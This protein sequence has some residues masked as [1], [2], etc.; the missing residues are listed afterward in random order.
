MAEQKP[1]P[2]PLP[3]PVEMVKPPDAAVVLPSTTRLMLAQASGA[4]ELVVVHKRTYTWEPG[5]RAWPADVQPPL[6][7]AGV[8]YPPIAEGRAPTWKSLPEVVGYKAGTDVVIHASARS[9]RPVERLSTVLFLGKRRHEVLV[10]GKRRT[11]LH[12]GQVVFTP[13]EP[14]TEVPLR[15]E[16]AYGGRDLFY[17]THFMEEVRRVTSAAIMRRATPSMEGLFTKVSPLM[18]PRNRFGQGYVLEQRAEQ[19]AGRELPQLERPDDL[20]TPERLMLGNPLRWWQQPM[21][22][23]F[24]YLD[25]MTFPRMGMFA[26]PPPGYQ[27]G[28]GVREVELG[29]VPKDFCRGNIVIATP[30]QLPTL[31][32]PHAG[33]CASLGLNFPY[34]RGDEMMLLQGMDA[35]GLE[36]D[37]LLPA[38]R[39]TMTVAGVEKKPLTL[40][41]EPYLVLVEVDTRQVVLVWAARH[42]L[43]QP[44]APQRLPAL[45]AATSVA[46]RRT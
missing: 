12:G 41:A 17:E 1:E 45:S 39:P 37:I 27:P 28:D 44:I 7:E 46:W 31:L 30:E 36:L 4:A 14:F 10:S 32:H 3:Q 20:L 13:P 9:P 19:Q 26:C 42:R 18:Y 38:E 35:K 24:D 34:L 29:L 8:L 40:N 6:D 25:P 15:Y 16:L 33:H 21:P 2:I 22:A 11:A 43:A 5:K 23:G